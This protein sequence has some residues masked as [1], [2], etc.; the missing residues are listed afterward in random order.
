[1]K[2]DLI[3]KACDFAQ[4]RHGEQK[5]DEGKNYFLTHCCIVAKLVSLITE[6]ENVKAAAYLHD[7]LEDTPT[8]YEEL[9]KEFGHT[10]ADLVL[11]VTHEGE[12]DNKGYYFPRLQSKDAILIKFADRLSNLSRMTN[13]SISRQRQYLEKSKFWIS[14]IS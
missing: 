11:E 5:D 10:V 12:K 2:V 7:I 13:W 4:K 3:S 1:M 9:K 6:D 8:T 14:E